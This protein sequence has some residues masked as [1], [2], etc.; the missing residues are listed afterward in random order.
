M[1]TTNRWSRHLPAFLLFLVVAI[2]LAAAGWTP[3]GAVNYEAGDFAANSLLIRDA[4]HLQ[5]LYGNYSRVGFNH[6]GPAILYVLAAGELL[7]HDVLHVVPSAFSG[8]LLA[9][10]LYNAGWIAL[11]FAL[12][13]RFLGAAAPALLALAV[14]LCVTTF[15]DYQIFTGIWFPH[16]YFFPY[17]VVLIALARLVYGH[18]DMLRAL[19]VASGFLINGHVSFV[20]M[21]GIMLIV[22]LAAN[23]RLTRTEPAL[24]MLSGGFLRSHRR[25]IVTACAILFVFLLPVIVVSI[26]DDPGSISQY[27]RF[28]RGNKGNTLPEALGFVAMYWGKGIAMAWGMLLLLLMVK[29]GAAAQHGQANDAP[30]DARTLRAFGIA[31]LGATLSLLYYAKVGIDQLEHTYIGLFYYS[32]P[33]LAA[34]V[35]VLMLLG[36]RSR[37]TVLSPRWL[38][39]PVALI[40]L[41]TVLHRA[42]E[43]ATYTNQYSRSGVPAM[44]DQLRALPGKGRF[45][46]D[47]ERSERSG[48]DVWADTLALQAYAA[49]RGVDVL[50]VNKE[51]HISNTRA[52]KCRPEEL[53][54][55]SR[56]FIVRGP[57]AVEKAEPDVVGLSLAL[58]Q[59]GGTPATGRFLAVKEDKD[60]FSGMLDGAWS[61]IDGEFAWSIGPIAHIRLPADAR[62]GDAITL[63]LGAFVPAPEVR[64]RLEI[65]INGKPSGRLEF[66]HADQRHQVRLALGDGAAAQDIELRIAEPRSPQELGLGADTRKL[67]V[68]LW[69]IRIKEKS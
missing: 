37:T 26:K 18:T 63:D 4:K 1:D 27:L 19:A 21:L 41:G 34:G 46:L 17:F 61:G 30:A 50:C 67:G 51:W 5:L 39:L 29:G 7:F 32:V 28:G 40:A 11:A 8:Q 12:L 57:E 60:L 16:L 54:E 65:L 20:P 10:C 2:A 62:R 13:R 24:R 59:V 9:V 35:G 58:Y 56:H 36:G 43:P 33:A 64:Q 48:G 68:A 49:R 44:Y 53:A 47:L 6:P 55:P 15:S 25:A 45:V 3:I 38:A 23:W 52:G 22:V 42:H 31:L 69:G 14:A 66:S